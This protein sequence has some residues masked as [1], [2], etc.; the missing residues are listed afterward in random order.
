MIVKQIVLSLLLLVVMFFPLRVVYGLLA[1]MFKKNK[2]AMYV[3]S[4]ARHIRLMKD[5]LKLLPWKRLVDLWCGDG[6]AMRFF[7][8]EFALQCDGYELQRVPYYYGKTLNSLLWYSKLTLYKQDFSQASLGR[9]DYIYLYL[10]PQQ[11]ADIEPRIF[12]NIKIGALVIS[13]SFQFVLHKPYKVIENSKGKAS[14][15]LYKK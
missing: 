6:K 9:Y 8:K 11:M 5:H 10:L 13:N 14:I 2:S 1:F 3:S 15:F 4:F 12:E 7:A